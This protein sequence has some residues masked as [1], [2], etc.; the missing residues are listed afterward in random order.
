MHYGW[1]HF[2]DLSVVQM[3]F[4]ERLA[5]DMYFL[6]LQRWLGIWDMSQRPLKEYYLH[7]FSVTVHQFRMCT[8]HQFQYVHQF[9][10]LSV[11]S[12]AQLIM[13]S[14]KHEKLCCY[15]NV[16]C[17]RIVGF[18]CLWSFFSH[19]QIWYYYKHKVFLSLLMYFNHSVGECW[20]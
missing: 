11:F 16:I 2:L 14:S 5:Q 3:N 8:V 6:T 19:K 9:W 7:W 1:N 17:G 13:F 18:H 10:T 12:L 20:V 15:R 4:L